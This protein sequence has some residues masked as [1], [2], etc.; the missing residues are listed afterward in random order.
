MTKYLEATEIVNYNNKEV[1]TLAM[2]LSKD[3]KS[4]VEIAKKCFEYV[5]DNINH[6]GDYKDEITT[7][8]IGD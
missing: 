7:N 6:L 1:Y 8:H 5:R 3:C 4:D 2:S